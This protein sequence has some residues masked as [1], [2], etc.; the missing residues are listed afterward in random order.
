MPYYSFFED[1]H[2]P[3][4]LQSCASRNDSRTDLQTLRNPR[5]K[6]LLRRTGLHWLNLPMAMA[7]L[8][9]SKVV[10]ILRSL[11]LQALVYVMTSLVSTLEMPIWR[12]ISRC[13]IRPTAQKKCWRLL[14]KQG[15]SRISTRFFTQRTSLWDWVTP[16]LLQRRF[17]AGLKVRSQRPSWWTIGN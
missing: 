6:L 11:R 8:P 17:K 7:I 2:V 13:K 16:N 5:P 12:K 1:V 15:T 10:V 9:A 4:F 14:R 3:Q